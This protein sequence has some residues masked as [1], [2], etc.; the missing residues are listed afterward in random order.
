MKQQPGFISTQLHRG[1]AG[2]TTLVNV[3]V[4]ESARALG[5]GLQLA[6]VP[7]KPGALSGEQRRD[8]TRLREGRGSGNLRGLRG[9]ARV[10][11]EQTRKRESPRSRRDTR[12]GR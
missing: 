9:G 1:T 11:A 7:T 10:V 8:A 4:W 6:R 2:S 5:R 3:A 12:G